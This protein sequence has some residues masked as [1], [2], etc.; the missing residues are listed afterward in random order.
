MTRKSDPIPMIILTLLF[1][2]LIRG[3]VCDVYSSTAHLTTVFNVEKAVVAQ[4]EKYIENSEAKTARL[5]KYVDA[6]NRIQGSADADEIIGNPISA[7]RFIKRLTK[8]WKNLEQLLTDNSWQ[9]LI[10]KMQNT[11]EDIEMPRKK[12]LEGAAVA[13]LRLQE[14]YQLDASDLA[15][16][17]IS[18][19]NR[20]LTGLTARD[21]IYL[22]KCSLKYELFDLAIEWYD[23]ALHMNRKKNIPSQ[24]IKLYLEEA[25][26]AHNVAWQTEINRMHTFQQT[27][28]NQRPA[29]MK[30]LKILKRAKKKH[31]LGYE[32]SKDE[33]T[34]NY[35]A[36]C[37]G[38]QLRLKV[39]CSQKFN[40]NMGKTVKNDSEE[41]NLNC[42]LSNRGDASF[43]INPIKIEVHSH[44]PSILTFHDVIYE[45]EINYIKKF[46]EPYLERSATVGFNMT[47]DRLMSKVRTS[48]SAWL[49]D[50][51]DDPISHKLK[52][53]MDRL[54]RVTGLTIPYGSYNSEALQVVNYGIG[55]HYTPHYDYLYKYRHPNQPFQVTPMELL[56]GDRLATL[57][58]YPLAAAALPDSPK[59]QSL[60]L[61]LALTI[62]MLLTL[63]SLSFWVNA[64]TY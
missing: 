52:I 22:G 62:T 23:H 25:I 64:K 24:K 54:S 55:G 11:L 30:K 7:Y 4:L 60:A 63:R 47:Q 46:S 28:I 33:D 43:Y 61:T 34:A 29:E 35:Y 41:A 12:D 17:N 59:N 1:L 27:I 53:I 9:N 48:Q 38:E 56:I 32:L 20:S 58:F 10:Q 16:G 49:Y 45:S 8:H 37:R 26:K 40:F 6:F 39:M 50:D 3:I 21:C 15:R 36:L 42:Y 19:L 5:R 13:I 14:T 31:K 57:M 18:G 51:L 44:N 2:I